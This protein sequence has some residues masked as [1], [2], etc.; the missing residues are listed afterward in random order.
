MEDTK[1]KAEQ[2]KQNV[3]RAMAK[4]T[5]PEGRL[6]VLLEGTAGAINA[7]SRD[8]KAKADA[9]MAFMKANVEDMIAAVFHG[10]KK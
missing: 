6:K 3:T 2:H 7:I 5:T 8:F 1:Q 9:E 10:V 4:E